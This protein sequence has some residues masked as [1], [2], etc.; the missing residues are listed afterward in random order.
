MRACWQR[1]NQLPGISRST[2]AVVPHTA[3]DDLTPDAAYF[4]VLSIN[5]VA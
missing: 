5:Q 2:M 4:G 1:D 3:N